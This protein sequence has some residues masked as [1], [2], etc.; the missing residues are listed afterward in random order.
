M[1][2]PGVDELTGEAPYGPRL[3]GEGYLDTIYGYL[4]TR[5]TK[6]GQRPCPG[7]MMPH[8]VVFKY[9]TIAQWFYT[10]SDGLIERKRKSNLNNED[11]FDMLCSCRAHQSCEVVAQYIKPVPRE[12]MQGTKLEIE[13]FDKEWLR[14]FLYER[15]KDDNAILQAFVDPIDPR[16]SVVRTFWSPSMLHLDKRENLNLLADARFNPFE[17]CCT[18]DGGKHLSRTAP[19]RDPTL[20]QCA[21]T[22][23]DAIH[24]HILAVTHG[25]A[26]IS[27]VVCFFKLAA[28]GHLW[29]LHV[30]SLALSYPAHATSSSSLA[31]PRT[32]LS[33]LSGLRR[34]LPPPTAQSA[35]SFEGTIASLPQTAC[36]RL[37]DTPMFSPP[38]TA[39]TAPITPISK[40]G[41]LKG[42]QM[43]NVHHT[44][45]MPCPQFR[46]V[47]AVCLPRCN[48]CWDT[49]A[50]HRNL[51][52]LPLS[53]FV[54][55]FTVD[56]VAEEQH[57]CELARYY[58]MYPPPKPRINAE[59]DLAMPC[60]VRKTFPKMRLD[61]YIR[62]RKD[63]IFLSTP[64][65][66]CGACY[67][68]F[69]EA[70]QRKLEA[71]QI[72]PCVYSHVLV[73]QPEDTAQG[74][75]SLHT[76]D[77]AQAQGA[78]KQRRKSARKPQGVAYVTTNSPWLGMDGIRVGNR[79]T[80]IF[81]GNRIPSLAATQQRLTP[82]LL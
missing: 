38:G 69:D 74:G 19:A 82:K 76:V 59:L 4:W 48:R 43:M 32:S 77:L 79:P 46:T 29:L 30:D 12:D 18:F 11:V 23:M 31:P 10:A 20:I 61:T 53:V 56:P 5:D 16:N 24:K 14:E 80:K 78:H 8:T 39:T 65:P 45:P 72:R 13:Y 17:R 25:K 37:A 42:V 6:S 22:K 70:L 7:I 63:T 52:E 35:K 54:D 41:G 62:L 27:R 3:D 2:P 40:P 1:L 21:K 34:E 26:N 60:A 15:P 75:A 58:A 67:V 64:V 44:E 81:L 73:R 28:D 50:S 55:E 36:T 9:G 49:V 47:A 66:V 57:L 68:H 33:S 71:S 51:K